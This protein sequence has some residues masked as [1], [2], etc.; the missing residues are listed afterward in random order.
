MTRRLLAGSSYPLIE[1][2]IA[3]YCAHTA[4]DSAARGI[5]QQ[6]AE[7]IGIESIRPLV[8]H[9]QDDTTRG[10]AR[11]G[12][13]RTARPIDGIVAD[14]RTLIVPT[15]IRTTRA[16]GRQRVASLSPVAA[17]GACCRPR[18]SRAAMP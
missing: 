16:A 8:P 13:Y 14:L 11:Y 7:A 6:L 12:E 5:N 17:P 3:V 10:A 18:R 9:A 4:Y 2:K 15:L 1:S